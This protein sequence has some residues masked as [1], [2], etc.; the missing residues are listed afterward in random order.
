MRQVR[1]PLEL[2]RMTA[3]AVNILIS[4]DGMY[5]LHDVWRAHKQRKDAGYEDPNALILAWVDCEY[6]VTRKG[7]FKVFKAHAPTGQTC[8]EHWRGSVRLR[9]WESVPPSRNP[10]I[11]LVRHT[12]VIR[13]FLLNNWPRCTVCGQRV[14]NT[15]HHYRASDG[16]CSVACAQIE[17]RLKKRKERV[18]RKVNEMIWRLQKVTSARKR[19]A[20][21]SHLMDIVRSQTPLYVPNQLPSKDCLYLERA[22]LATS[23]AEGSGSELVTQLLERTRC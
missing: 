20:S 17:V 8:Y 6:F 12:A 10:L 2:R 18:W 4:S 9:L 1:R 14:F 21:Q 3:N 5:G 15:D 13:R 16:T 7:F 19:Q 23:S 22:S 11:D